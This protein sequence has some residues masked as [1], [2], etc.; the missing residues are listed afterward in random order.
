[1]LFANF[2]AI[3]N[4]G[5]QSFANATH[6]LRTHPH[7]AG[8]IRDISFRGISLGPSP[9]APTTSRAVLEAEDVLAVLRM[10]SVLHT[11]RVQHCRWVPG[12]MGSRYT[13][14]THIRLEMSSLYST[15]DVPP[16]DSLISVATGWHTV[17]IEDADWCSS[18]RSAPDTIQTSAVSLEVVLSGG[19]HGES[20][21]EGLL[22]VQHLSLRD[23]VA[24]DLAV[25]QALVS[26]H[27]KSLRS[28]CL[29]VE[30]DTSG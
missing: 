14:A 1:M 8:V 25:A 16:C 19:T 29:H 21:I 28:V 13:S 15:T 10:C 11:V 5:L 4:P 6:F 23:L 24:T 30:P 20:S 17:R 7:I 22:G 9:T 18:T 2:V 26:Q 12:P 27:A 3:G